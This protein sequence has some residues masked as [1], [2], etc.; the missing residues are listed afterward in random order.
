M[1]DF[2]KKVNFSVY[3]D[4]VENVRTVTPEGRVSQVIGLIAEG[5]SLG[6]GVGGVCRIIND[7]GMAVMA[8]VVG[9]R[10][11]KALFMPF[12]E[13]RGI[14]MGSRIVPVASSPMVPVGDDMLGRVMDG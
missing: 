1:A 2:F 7:R 5:D 9:F 12:G 14:S 6:L 4:A 13:I 11:E 8:E 10:Q 3:A